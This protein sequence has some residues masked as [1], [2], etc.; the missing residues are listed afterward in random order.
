MRN[1][2][3]LNDEHDALQDSLERMVERL[4]NVMEE[5]AVLKKVC[6]CV[7]VCVATLV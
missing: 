7:C 5:K 2:E 6:V 4:R 1:M 3:E